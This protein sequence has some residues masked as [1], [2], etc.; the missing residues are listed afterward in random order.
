MTKFHISARRAAS[1]AAIVLGLTLLGGPASA[2]LVPGLGGL[3]AVS[4]GPLSV[5]SGGVSLGGN[6]VVSL[7][8]GGVTLGSGANAISLGSGSGGIGGI[9]LGTD[10]GLSLGAGP[11]QLSVGAGGDL[12]DAGIGAEPANAQISVGMPSFSGDNFFSGG[13]NL[14]STGA[15]VGLGL[16]GG[17]SGLI[18]ASLGVSPG[19]SSTTVVSNTGGGG[20]GGVAIGGFS[21]SYASGDNRLSC[22]QVRK[23][24]QYYAAKVV[25]YCRLARSK[26]RRAAQDSARR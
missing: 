5:G 18:S 10:Q 1:G 4:L 21:A 6:N 20:G 15:S 23:A 13:A 24:P 25:R 2:Q 3:G 8:S 16:P 9:S 17:K 19:G 14:G 7:G 22:A 11:A 12:A 26:Q